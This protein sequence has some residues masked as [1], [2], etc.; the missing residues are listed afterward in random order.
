M[1]ERGRRGGKGEASGNPR[2]MYRWSK[3]GP[4]HPRK[5]AKKQGD[6]KPRR[7]SRAPLFPSQLWIDRRGGKE[8][9]EQKKRKKKGEKEEE[10]KEKNTKKKSKRER[11]RENTKNYIGKLNGNIFVCLFIFLSPHSRPRLSPRPPRDA[12]EN[13]NLFQELYQIK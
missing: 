4:I 11:E 12:K 5:A 3:P 7:V 10:A 6:H 8:G 9:E 13:R 1:G 2:W